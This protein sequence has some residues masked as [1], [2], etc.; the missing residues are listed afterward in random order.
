MY[1]IALYCFY[2][3]LEVYSSGRTDPPTRKNS[4]MESK[5]DIVMVQ[6]HKAPSVYH[7]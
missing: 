4:K 1:T 6:L 7:Q 3:K 2:R 5:E